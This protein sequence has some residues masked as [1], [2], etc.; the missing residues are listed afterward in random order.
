M[1]NLRQFEFLTFAIKISFLFDFCADVLLNPPVL[2]AVELDS[3]V[4]VEIALS[5][6]RAY[7]Q[8]CHFRYF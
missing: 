6:L 2:Y 1:Q 7:L 5:Q 3:V 8:R 4:E